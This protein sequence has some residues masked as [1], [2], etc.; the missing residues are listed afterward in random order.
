MSL[1]VEVAHRAAVAL[2]VAVTLREHR[3]HTATGTCGSKQTV[4]QTNGAI[5]KWGN[6]QA[7]HQ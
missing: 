3:E 2:R 6:K 4:Q 1:D 7:G 5:I